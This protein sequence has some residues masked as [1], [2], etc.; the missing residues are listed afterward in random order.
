MQATASR[1]RSPYCGGSARDECR[2]SVRAP[3]VENRDAPISIGQ[4]A[5][6]SRAFRLSDFVLFLSQPFRRQSDQLP[7]ALDVL[8]LQRAGDLPHIVTV[9]FRE[10]F[11]DSSD[12]FDN[13]VT[14]HG[15]YS[16]NSSGVQRPAGWARDA[17][18]ASNATPPLR[19]REAFA[20]SLAAASPRLRPVSEQRESAAI[21]GCIRSD[22]W[23]ELAR[24]WIDTS[25]PCGARLTSLR[26]RS[27]ACRFLYRGP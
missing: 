14:G 13:R 8:L 24:G 15:S 21:L 3:R 6:L 5:N 17:G 10:G 23:P 26:W 4:G 20:E 7:P 12:F 18:R 22:G 2:A 25:A 9:L 1:S 27:E 16:I 19:L 11:A